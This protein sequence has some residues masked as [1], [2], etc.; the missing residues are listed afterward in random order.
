MF[1]GRMLFIPA[2][3]A[4]ED[5]RKKTGEAPAGLPSVD[6]DGDAVDLSWKGWM[7]HR[8]AEMIVILDRDIELRQGPVRVRGDR[9]V[10]VFDGQ[11]R[12]LRRARLEGNVGLYRNGGTENGACSLLAGRMFWR[13]SGE[14]VAENVILNCDGVERTAETMR[15][16]ATSRKWVEPGTDH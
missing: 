13:D 16:D 6:W 11:G 3:P 2:E 5:R 15:F 1:P 10:L 7:E 8:M 9:M 12:S 4:A 14:V